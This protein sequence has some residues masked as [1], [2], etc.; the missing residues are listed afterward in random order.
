MSFSCDNG[1]QQF[2]A[3][4]NNNNNTTRSGARRPAV[5]VRERLRRSGA[6]AEQ[7]VLW[8]LRSDGLLKQKGETAMAVHALHILICAQRVDERRTRE[9]VE[10]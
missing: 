6:R 2:Q 4:N 3:N 1:D 8:D 9:D 10:G 5:H 7:R